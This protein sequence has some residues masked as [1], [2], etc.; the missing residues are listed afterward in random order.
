MGDRAVIRM[1]AAA[2]RHKDDVLGA[3][4]LDLS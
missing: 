3:S 4:P 2:E 1:V